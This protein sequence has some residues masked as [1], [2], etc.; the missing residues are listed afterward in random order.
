[1]K[2]TKISIHG[3]DGMGRGT[4]CLGAF[5]IKYFFCWQTTKDLIHILTSLLR[6]FHKDG[7]LFLYIIFWDPSCPLLQSCENASTTLYQ[8]HPFKIMPLPLLHMLFH[9]KYPCMLWTNDF[10]NRIWSMATYSTSI[11]FQMSILTIIK[12]M[13]CSYNYESGFDVEFLGPFWY[14]IC[15]L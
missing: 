4:W 1:M 8:H 12:V 13:N 2:S 10:N 7:V 14:S 3:F 11:S 15:K 9:N 6:P 5:I